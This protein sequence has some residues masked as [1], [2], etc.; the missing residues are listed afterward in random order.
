MPSVGTSI[1]EARLQPGQH[2]PLQKDFQGTAGFC[3]GRK[4]FP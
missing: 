4:L 2:V 1:V 3:R